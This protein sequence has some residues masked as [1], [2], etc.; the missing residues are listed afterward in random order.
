VLGSWNSDNVGEDDDWTFEGDA[1]KPEFDG[2]EDDALSSDERTQNH[3]ALETYVGRIRA[4]TDNVAAGLSQQLGENVSRLSGPDRD[5][6]QELF[7]ERLR[8]EA[9]FDEI[10][11]DV[12]EDIRRRFDYVRAGELQLR[13]S[14][15]PELWTYKTEDRGEFIRQIRWFSSNY[16]PEFG[17]LLTPLVDGVRVKGPLHPAFNNIE[18]KIVLLDGQGLGHTPDSSASVTTHI[19]RRFGDVDVILLV[20]NAQ[21]P[22][23]AASLAVLRAVASSGHYQKLAIAFTH[24]DQVKGLNLPGY[25][26]KRGHVMASVV[27]GLKNLSEVLGAPIVKAI[28]RVLDRHCFMLGALQEVNLKLPGGVIKELVR[29]LGFFEKAIEPPPQAEARPVYDTTGLLFAVQ[30]AASDFQ[31]P[32]AARLGIASY[33]GIA[34]EHWTRIKALNRRIAGELDDEYDTLRPVADLVARLTERISLFLDNPVRW[35]RDPI[36]DDEVQAAISVIR[37]GVFGTLHQFI[38]DRLIATHL[39]DWRVAFSYS[40]RGSTFDRA[41]DI[42]DIYETAA[43]VP[44]VVV[45]QISVQFLKE[46][47]SIVHRAIEGSG[48][49]LE[50][51]SAA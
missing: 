10:V 24:F 30:A 43:P 33:N 37:Q 46:I 2:E 11:Q 26:E 14:G 12:L 48:G 5:A 34:R 4:L 22:M 47:R 25:A 35:T 41:R 16:A 13:R 40:G 32:W 50:L 7:E 20:D 15:W 17:R 28:E 1:T 39:Q 19:T 18:P 36:D 31:R 27:N 45:T 23:Q 6:A 21:Q 3:A 8:S 29:M 9:S 49:Q 44:G 42:R 38:T 51:A